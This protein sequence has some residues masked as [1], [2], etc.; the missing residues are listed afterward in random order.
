MVIWEWKKLVAKGKKEEADM[1]E[2]RKR[3]RDMCVVWLVLC[4]WEFSLESEMGKEER[5]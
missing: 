2:Q 4:R 5:C 1:E 3:E